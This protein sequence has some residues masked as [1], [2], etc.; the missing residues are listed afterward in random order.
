MGE[1]HFDT[2]SRGW[3]V[4]V[5]EPFAPRRMRRAASIPAD[6][7]WAGGV[8]PYV[9]DASLQDMLVTL[10]QMRVAIRE[11]HL[12]CPHIR[13]VPRSGEEHYVRFTAGSGCS[14]YIGRQ[15]MDGGQPITLQPVV[16]EGYPSCGVSATIHEVWVQNATS[17]AYRLHQ[18]TACH[19]SDHT[20]A[21]PRCT[22]WTCCGALPRTVTH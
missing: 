6:M 21:Y 11:F 15:P 9:V 10:H 2:G 4:E 13:L 12:R 1:A 17:Q 3:Q 22:D 8:V 7:F 19:P 5:S 14:S 16:L 18:P 20:M